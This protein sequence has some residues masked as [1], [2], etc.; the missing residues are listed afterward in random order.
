VKQS[1]PD[2][3]GIEKK[4]TAELNAGLLD[5]FDYCFVGLLEKCKKPE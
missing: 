4:L 2:V 1:P 3:K 5:A